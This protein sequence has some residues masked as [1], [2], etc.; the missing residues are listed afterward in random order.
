M[1]VVPEVIPQPL[2]EGKHIHSAVEPL[3]CA[4]VLKTPVDAWDSGESRAFM[5]VVTQ[6]YVA[7]EL[8]TCMVWP[9]SCIATRCTCVAL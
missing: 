7:C 6:T 9:H 5:F 2:G 1:W 8:Y 4:C 3:I